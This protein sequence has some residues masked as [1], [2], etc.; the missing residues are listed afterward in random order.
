MAIV[1]RKI[2]ILCRYTLSGLCR[3]SRDG[4]S[5]SLQGCFSLPGDLSVPIIL[6]SSL[7][8]TPGLPEVRV[9]AWAA[10]LPSPWL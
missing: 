10:L 1:V 5:A 4:S 6:P 7:A 2:Q 8:V 3:N 9:T